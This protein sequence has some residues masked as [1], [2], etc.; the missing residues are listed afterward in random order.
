MSTCARCGAE[1]RWV[2]VKGAGLVPLDA[3]TTYD[4]TYALDP[5]DVQKA[6]PIS[7]PGLYG[8]RDHNETCRQAIR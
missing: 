8:Y 6:Y 3:H 2:E 5:N 7:R 1:I 4:G